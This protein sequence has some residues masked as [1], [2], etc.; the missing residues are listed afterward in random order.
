VPRPAKAAE[1][2]L[3]AADGWLL[4]SHTHSQGKRVLFPF[5]LCFAS[6]FGFAKLVEFIRD[7]KIYDFYDKT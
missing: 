7:L 5:S 1:G 4:M 6:D 3:E 2:V